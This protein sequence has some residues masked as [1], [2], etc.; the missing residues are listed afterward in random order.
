MANSCDFTFCHQCTRVIL[1]GLLR[2]SARIRM[3]VR[4]IAMSRR[5]DN[6]DVL[7]SLLR[8]SA[9]VLRRAP[10]AIRR[11]EDW[12]RYI[13]C[14]LDSDMGLYTTDAYSILERTK[15]LYATSK[16]GVL[17]INRLPKR[18]LRILRRLRQ[19]PR[20]ISQCLLNSNPWSN[21]NPK[22]QNSEARWIFCEKKL[23]PPSASTSI[24][25]FE[26]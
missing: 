4:K 17:S 1:R 12:N 24:P 22:R 25:A 6:K 26:R 8:I 14:W 21:C 18:A 9:G 16:A 23:R 13:R 5:H 19:S 10:S 11:Q 20:I 3:Y 15:P 7:S 2:G